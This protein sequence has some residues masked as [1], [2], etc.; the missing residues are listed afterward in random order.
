MSQAKV[1]VNGKTMLDGNLE[2]WQKQPPEFLQTLLKQKHNAAPW[3]IAAGMTLMDAFSHQQPI[4][5]TITTTTTG[6]TMTVTHSSITA[7]P[8]AA[9]A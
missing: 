2:H 4:T 9:T 1:T 5:I 7:I 6:W 8:D 3:H